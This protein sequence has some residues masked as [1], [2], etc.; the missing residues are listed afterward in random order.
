MKILLVEDSKTTRLENERVLTEVGYEVIC[1]E[2]GESALRQAQEQKPDLILLE[3]I[4]RKISGQEVLRQLKCDARTNDIPVVVLTG[5]S[6]KNR[7]K[8]IEAGAEDYFEKNLLMP[9]PGT[10][11]L[12][13]M[14][15]NVIC[16]VNRRKSIALAGAAIDKSLEPA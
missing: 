5:L 13:Q 12:P 9:V 15:D 8:L 6:E 11:I 14:L 7:D 1:A 16:R 10:N 4:L 3:M 2:D